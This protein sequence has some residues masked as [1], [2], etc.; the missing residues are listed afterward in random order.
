MPVIHGV[1]LAG[2]SG[3]RLW[4]RGRAGRPKQLLQLPGGGTLLQRAYSRLARLVEVDRVLVTT[5]ADLAPAVRDELQD[6][7][8]GDL[9]LEPSVKD[10]AAAV[11]LA[12]LV[13]LETDPEAIMLVTP[14]DQHITD[15]A[16]FHRAAATAVSVASGSEAARLVLVGTPPTRPA[17]GYGYIRL[18]E[19]LITEDGV[20]V[21]EVRRF[22]EKPGPR[23]ARRYTGGERRY[24]W[25]TGI[26]AFGAR[27]ILDYISRYLPELHQGLDQIRRAGAQGFEAAVAEHYPGL[28]SISIDR[29]IMERAR[30]LVC[31]QGDFTWEDMGSLGAMALLGRPDDAGNVVLGG[32]HISLETEGS[33]VDCPGKLV[34]T[35]GVSDLIIID[36]GDILLIVP[37]S[38][39]QDV[40]SLRDRL[41]RAGL[42]RYL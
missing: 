1:L 24:L 20:S 42:E 30:R 4:P 12:A 25:N 5:Q 2:G 22:R 13:A 18:G 21:Y 6:L 15:D 29:G 34:A 31:V 32:R 10:T 17:T 41:R 27:T 3:S 39:D 38:R 36:T 28:P 35:I 26:C 40:R 7:T 19:R 37:R 33:L 23:R 11:G 14:S 16:A 9:V 8:P